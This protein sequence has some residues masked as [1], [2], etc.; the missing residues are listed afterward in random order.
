M[1]RYSQVIQRAGS[2]KT[3]L[4]TLTAGRPYSL[5][6]SPFRARTQREMLLLQH[7]CGVSTTMGG[8]CC[9]NMSRM[10]EAQGTDAVLPAGRLGGRPY[11]GGA[12]RKRTAT[13]LP[14]PLAQLCMDRSVELGIPLSDVIAMYCALGAG[15]PVPEYI[16]KQ[17]ERHELT[18]TQSPLLEAS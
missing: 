4:W 13:S 9:G 18:D 8:F 7:P 12:P 10:S 11:K 1:S 2:P 15:M 14:G 6:S 5:T 3:R 17:L 16:A